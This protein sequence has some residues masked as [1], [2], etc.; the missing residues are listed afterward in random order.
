MT[1]APLYIQIN[2]WL[3]LASAGILLMCCCIPL[4]LKKR[5]RIEGATYS[6]P[7]LSGVFPLQR[8][9][10]FDNVL[11]LSYIAFTA[12]IYASASTADSVA[13]NSQQEY[14]FIGT[15]I[16]LLLPIIIYLP[17]IVRYMIVFYPLKGLSK[18]H[19]GYTLLCLTGIYLSIIVFVGLSG[20]QEWIIEVTG[21]PETQK[22]VQ[23]LKDASFQDFIILTIS[24]TI[25]APFVEEIV[26][27]G[28]FFRVISYKIG[29]IAAAILSSVLFSSIHLSLAQ[30]PA[31]TIFALFQCYLYNK[32]Q[33]IIYPMMLHMAF[34]LIGVLMTL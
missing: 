10:I 2:F 1:D 14:T 26:F 32:T 8:P 16:S 20:F 12:L 15:I 33:S 4:Q 23:N 24:A 22:A 13:E 19:C 28:F 29:L 27:R 6:L 31:L 25:I 17:L 11:T 9:R 5:I 30:T 7:L 21:T 34:N 18:R 3:I